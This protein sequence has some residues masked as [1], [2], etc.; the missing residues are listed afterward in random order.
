MWLTDGILVTFLE[1]GEAVHM[2][3]VQLPYIVQVGS[4]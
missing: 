4:G 3:H 2:S 1:S